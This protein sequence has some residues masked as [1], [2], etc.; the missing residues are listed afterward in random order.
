MEDWVLFATYMFDSI[1]RN[2]DDIRFNENTI[3][4]ITE[5]PDCEP[6]R[7]VF[8]RKQWF[9]LFCWQEQNGGYNL[10]KIKRDS[11]LYVIMKQNGVLD[12]CRRVTKQNKDAGHFLNGIVFDLYVVDDNT[13]IESIIYSYKGACR[14]I[15]QKELRAL[16][17]SIRPHGKTNIKKVEDIAESTYFKNGFDLCG[18][19]KK[20]FTQKSAYSDRKISRICVSDVSCTKKTYINNNFR[21]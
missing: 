8:S 18:F 6:V 10:S 3:W 21:M 20:V 16:V 12:F 7:V 4:E 5:V 1:R 17:N 9:S 2:K 11:K 15:P 14:N 19:V 13:Y